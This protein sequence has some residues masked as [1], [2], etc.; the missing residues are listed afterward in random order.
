MLSVSGKFSVQFPLPGRVG[1]AP[2]QPL[3]AFSTSE[4]I[5]SRLKEAPAE[6]TRERENVLFIEH[7]YADVCVKLYIHPESKKRHHTRV[8]N[9]AKY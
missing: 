6:V 1:L 4:V 5:D 2:S 3:P 7:H 8:D 9:F